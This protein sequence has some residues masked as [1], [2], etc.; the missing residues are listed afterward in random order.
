M[1]WHDW[2]RNIGE[3]GNLYVW[4]FL[5]LCSAAGLAWR[6]FRKYLHKRRLIKIIRCK[7]VEA[8]KEYDAASPT[9]VFNRNERPP[10]KGD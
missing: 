10:Y 4:I 6:D 9:P 7:G 2:Q 8:A 5:L 3:W 1:S